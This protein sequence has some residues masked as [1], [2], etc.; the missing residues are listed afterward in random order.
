MDNLVY[1][2]I[3]AKFEVKEI[4]DDFISIE[5]LASTFGNIDRSGDIIA[6]GA[7]SKTLANP[8]R[9]LKL[10]NQHK[11]SEPLG[12]IDKAIET[13]EGLFIMARMPKANSVVADLVPLLRMGAI[14]DFSIGFNIQDSDI[15][16]DGNRI[17]KEIDLFEVSL[18]TIPANPMA[19][20]TSVK[21]EDMVSI[22]DVEDIK[23]KR[24]F[25]QMLSDTKLF[26]R[27]ACVALASR[28]KEDEQSESV[29]LEKKEQRDSV[30]DES[31]LDELEKI[32]QLF[33]SQGK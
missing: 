25:E 31:V 30:L 23:T 1:K 14:S 10:L 33:Q 3:I 18:V 4:A 13:D 29:D 9:K 16:P 24:D 21:Q 32:K 8:E 5:G 19:R 26:T 20:I 28:F 7:F 11:L 12:V 22:S 17:I 15:T 6:K 2:N 27:K